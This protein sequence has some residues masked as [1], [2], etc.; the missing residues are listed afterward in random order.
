MY[1]TTVFEIAQKGLPWG[2]VSPPLVLTAAFALYIFVFRKSPRKRDKRYLAIG[3][4]II[5]IFLCAIGYAVAIPQYFA[6]RRAYREGNFS[7]VEGRVENFRPM[8]FDGHQEESF[9][10]G[11]SRFSYSDF[12]DTPGFNRTASHGGPIRQGLLV[13]ISYSD[14]CSGGNTNCILKLEIAPGK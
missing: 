7:I 12:E 4:L 14:E 3:G 2:T 11:T 9:T 5:I 6:C 1:Y 8:P 10:V 13:R